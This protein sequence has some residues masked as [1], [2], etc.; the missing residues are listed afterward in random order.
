MKKLLVTGANGL[1]GSAVRKIYSDR[2]DVIYLTKQDCDLSDFEK[3][4]QVFGDYKP[5][6]VLHF[7]AVVGGLGSNSLHSGEFFRNNILINVNVLESARLAGV[8]KLISFMSTC[9]F[10]DKIT[11]PLNEQDLHNGAPHPSNFGYAYAKRMLDV[12]STAYRKEWGCNYITAIPTNVFGPHDNFNLEN[13]HVTSSLIHKCYIAMQTNQPLTVWGTGSPL[14]EFVFS[15]DVAKLSLWM[16]EN[17]NEEIPI[18]L[19]SGIEYSIK[20]LV[21]AVVKA[22]KFKGHVIFDISK[23]EGQFRKPSD[24]TKMK[25]YLPDFKFTPLQEGVDKTVD[26]FLNNYSTARI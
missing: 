12:Q 7:A 9:I 20:D 21:E 24:P 2:D 8:N 1:I 14:R 13:G 17:Y 23:P 5:E 19:T 18:I 26:W 22:M 16:L 15:E 6:K 10:P 4:K 3:T 25:K 11:Y